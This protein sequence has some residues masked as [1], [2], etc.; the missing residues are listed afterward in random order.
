MRQRGLLLAG[1]YL[2]ISKKISPWSYSAPSVHH[3]PKLGYMST[4]RLITGKGNDVNTTGLGHSGLITFSPA[5]THTHRHWA[6]LL[7]QRQSFPVPPT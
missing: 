5:P 3:W 4:L 7:E 2:F 1:S 6:G